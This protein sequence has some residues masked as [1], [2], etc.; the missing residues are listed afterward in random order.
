VQKLVKKGV[1][2]PGEGQQILT[3]TKEEMRKSIAQGKSDILPSWLQKMNIKGDLRIR[4]QYEDKTGS[5][6]RHRGR[7]RFRLGI[8][9]KVNDKLKVAAG[10]ATGGS[11][12]RSTNQ[13]MDTGFATPDI[14]LD[15]AYAEYAAAPWAT[16]RAGKMKGIKNQLFRPTDLMWDSDINP[17]GATLNLKKKVSDNLELFGNLGVWMLEEGSGTTSDQYMVVGQPGFTWKVNKNVKLQS[18][19]ALYFM[20]D[21]KGNTLSNGSDSSGEYNTLTGAGNLMYEYNVVNPNFKLS[22]TEPFGGIV[23]YASLF[24]EFVHNPDPSDENN[25]WIAGISFGS[26][27]VKTAGDWQ[28]KYMYRYLEKDAWLDIFPDSDAYSGHTDAKGHEIA[29]KYGLGKNTWL[30]LDYYYMERIKGQGRR[31]VFQVDWN[32]Q[33]RRT[34]F[35]LDWNMKF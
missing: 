22:I 16:V 10:L 4:Y 25:G 17:E 19:V 35:Q 14:R 8:E 12:A 1:L 33:G 24:G 7:Y 6:D 23:P 15:Y 28:F 9:T 3:E 34:V 13:T 29:F 11:D 20:G 32:I 27:K 18:A 2:T 21:V 30:E 31:T 26:K 5:E